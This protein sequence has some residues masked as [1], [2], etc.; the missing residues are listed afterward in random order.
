MILP[1]GTAQD[2]LLYEEVPILVHCILLCRKLERNLCETPLMP[3]WL[4]LSS[5]ISLSQQSYAFDKSKNKEN[6]INFFSCEGITKQHYFNGIIKQRLNQYLKQSGPRQ[7]EWR[8]ALRFEE[9][10]AGHKERNSIAIERLVCCSNRPN[11]FCTPN[12]IFYSRV[13]FKFSVCLFATQK[14][15]VANYEHGA[16]ARNQRGRRGGFAPLENFC[17][18]WKNVLDIVWKYWTYF[19]R[20]GPLLENSSPLLVSQAGYG[21]DG[22]HLQCK[23][24]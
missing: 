11:F 9:K 14:S 3:Q 22:A 21:L 2:T 23:A 24:S 12:I 8:A 7:R 13:I 17:S 1:W 5:K 19:K 6:I 16:Q 10:L 4:S 20:F 18:P 15:T